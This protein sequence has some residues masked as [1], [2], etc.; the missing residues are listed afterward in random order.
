MVTLYVPFATPLGIG[1]SN[2]TVVCPPLAPIVTVW[3]LTS[4][5]KRQLSVSIL[6]SKVSS[7]LP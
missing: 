7:V 2:E 5:S 6:M 3:E 1:S 4:A